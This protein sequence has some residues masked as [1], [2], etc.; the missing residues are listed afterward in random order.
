[1]SGSF[2]DSEIDSIVEKFS[3]EPVIKVL[4]LLDW[5]RIN[6]LSNKA[7][8]TNVGKHRIPYSPVL[9]TKI[10][11]LQSMYGYSD[12][13]MEKQLHFNL[14]FMKFCGLST[15]DRK[16]DHS[17]ISKWRDRFI[18]ENIH[19]K[20]FN[21]INRQFEELGLIMKNGSVIDATIIS[22][23]ARPRRKQLV[24]NEDP[25]EN[26][27][28]DQ[29]HD[30]EDT[31]KEIETKEQQIVFE[32]SKDPDARYLVKGKKI[33]YGYKM[34]TAV[35]PQNGLIQAVMTTAANIPDCKLLE[36]I[37]KKVD[38]EKDSFVFADK[39]YAS[40]SNRDLLKGLN[41][42]D[43]I[44]FKGSRNRPLSELQKLGNKRISTVRYKVEQPYGLIKKRNGGRAQLIGMSKVSFANTMNCIIHNVVRSLKFVCIA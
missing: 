21:E 28:L 38:L 10:F 15:T 41:L 17:T 16:P 26:V 24:I 2:I 18:K 14:L 5:S 13:A 23:Q 1:M 32:E 35:D 11:L 20:L 7:K 34:T 12:V 33:H 43:G 3:D 8:L 39:G 6:K 27:D 19:D 22:S 37:L 4:K 30:N 31:E 40:A 9:M 29:N 25:E 36:G 42:K 44:M